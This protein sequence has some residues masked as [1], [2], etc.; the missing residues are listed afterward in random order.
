MARKTALPCTMLKHG[1]PENVSSASD[2]RTLIAP[3]FRR[4]KKR[5]P[6]APFACSVAVQSAISRP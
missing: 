1:G 4:H 3:P 5:R 6:R 2:I